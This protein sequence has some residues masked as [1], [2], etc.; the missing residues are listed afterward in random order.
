MKYLDGFDGIYQ[1]LKPNSNLL[2]ERKPAISCYC[3]LEI[4][5]SLEENVSS[6]IQDA[7]KLIIDVTYAKSCPT[8]SSLKEFTSI[9]SGLYQKMEGKAQYQTLVADS[10]LHGKN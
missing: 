8:I 1:F 5:I 3:W 4:D 6:Y 9:A 10:K 2:K 7:S